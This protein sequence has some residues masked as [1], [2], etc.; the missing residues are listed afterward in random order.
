M[1]FYIYHHNDFDGIAAAGLFSKFFCLKYN[2]NFSDFKFIP[3]DYDIKSKWV[4]V[5]I[6]KPCAV[7]DFL[8]H[9]NSDWWFDHH[10][11]PI[12]DEAHKIQPYKPSAKKLWSPDYPSCS[13]LI[14]A[15]L[16]R[17][18][19][20]EYI[21]L[22]KEYIE[23]IEWSDIIDGAGYKTLDEIFESQNDYINLN[24][25]LEVTSDKNYY[26]NVIESIFHNQ[27]SIFVKNNNSFQDLLN[28]YKKFR[29]ESLNIFKRRIELDDCIALIDQSNYNFPFQ[30]YLAFYM[31]PQVHYCIGIINM[32][33]YYKVSINFNIWQD[34]INIF[35]IGKLCKDFGGGGRKNVGAII[36]ETY[37][38][39]VNVAISIKKRLIQKVEP[40][41]L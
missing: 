32:G 7:L 38:D 26:L 31:F 13:S 36:K 11:D 1:A 37:D 8:Y 24:R 19:S 29:F 22:K 2:L 9:P 10:T 40:N 27:I 12:S 28:K 16:N 39:A 35:N 6:K 5:N 4:N 30:R 14:M 18:F 33:Q 21:E 3:V 25:T 15:N 34:S 41:N 17:F 23:L 20:T